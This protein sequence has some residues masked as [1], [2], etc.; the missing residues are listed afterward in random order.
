MK[1]VVLEGPTAQHEFVVAGPDATIGR[2]PDC[3]IRL[4]DPQVSRHHARLRSAGGRVVLEDLQPAN[5]SIVNDRLVRGS[6]W[7]EH[8]DLIVVGGVLLQ[9]DLGAERARW[10]A[11][12]QPTVHRPTEA[13]SPSV[14]PSGQALSG[15]SHAPA[16]SGPPAPPATSGEPSGPGTTGTQRERVRPNVPARSDRTRPPAASSPPRTPTPQTPTPQTPTPQTPTPSTPAV[17]LHAPLVPP[18]IPTPGALRAGARRL[19]AAGEQLVATIAPSVPPT[20]EQQSATR[21]ALLRLDRVLARHQELGGDAELARFA[22]LLHARLS[23]QTDLTQLF[24]LGAE[25]GA[26]GAWT[27]LA[28]EAIGLIDGLEQASHGTYR[29]V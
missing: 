17:R 26:M 2:A 25:A 18:A 13:G 4:Y 16:Q 10:H 24:A 1:L 8:G 29:E 9:L 22:A 20:T 23:N 6:R 3:A 28:H 11:D 21:A 27:R 7:L 5:P 12:R 15:A 14:E 19:K